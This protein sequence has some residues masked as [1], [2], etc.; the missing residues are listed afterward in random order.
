MEE[1]E[2]ISRQKIELAKKVYAM[3][4]ANLGKLNKKMQ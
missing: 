2:S 3:V 1:V 4:E